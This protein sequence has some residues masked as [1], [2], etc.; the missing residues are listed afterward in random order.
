MVRD[1]VREVVAIAVDVVVWIAVRA[2]LFGCCCCGCVGV[3]VESFVTSVVVL[4]SES[5]LAE[6]SSS[7]LGTFL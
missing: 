5:A 6:H 7:K 1:V 4:F 2:H 3:H